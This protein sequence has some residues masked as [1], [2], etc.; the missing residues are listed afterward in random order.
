MSGNMI[1][2]CGI[3]CT[4]C[5]DGRQLNGCSHCSHCLRC[6]R[7]A[8]LQYSLDCADCT[9]CFGCV[10]LSGAEFHILNEPHDRTDY[11]KRTAQLR[12]ELD[13]VALDRLL[14]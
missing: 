5:R 6:T 12:A 7:S 3:D 2:V 4:H 11:F 9:Y 14:R 8:Y 13:S 10:G 1:A